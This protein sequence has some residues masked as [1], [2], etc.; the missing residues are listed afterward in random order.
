MEKRA[1]E[2][3]DQTLTILKKESECVLASERGAGENKSITDFYQLTDRHTSKM[4]VLRDDHEKPHTDE[5]EE[6][7][8]TGYLI[9]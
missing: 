1:K 6:V 7:Y 5:Y 2:E 3:V 8:D 4:S 9:S